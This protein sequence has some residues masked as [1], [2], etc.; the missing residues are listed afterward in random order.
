MRVRLGVCAFVGGSLAVAACSASS[1]RRSEVD[2]GAGGDTS[3]VAVSSGSKGSSVQSSGVGDF[4]DGGLAGSGGGSQGDGCSEAAKLIYVV[5]TTYELY[6]FNPESLQFKQ[7]GLLSC[8]AGG[9]TPFSMAVDRNATA[10]VLYNNGQ[11]FHVDTTTAECK[12]TNFVPG[13]Q[14]FTT[15]GMGFVSDS[16]GSNEEKIY[17]GQY[18]GYQLGRLDPA[19]MTVTNVGSYDKVTGAAEITGTGDARL[20]GFFLVGG[21]SSVAELDKSNAQVISLAPTGA[22]IGSGWAFAFWGGSF[23]LFTAPSGNSQVTRFTLDPVNPNTGKS[24]VVVPSVGFVIV[25]AGVSTCAP[26]EP[27]H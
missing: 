10:W 3:S 15:F 14:G 23:Y 17:L 16:P 25:G 6:S 12:P 2:D 4:I 26:V 18:E 19:T 20:F 9:S 27:P 13:Q 8:P 22:T 11:L 24:E 1:S 7:I 21:S 5:G